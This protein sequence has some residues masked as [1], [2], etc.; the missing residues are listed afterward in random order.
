MFSRMQERATI[1]ENSNMQSENEIVQNIQVAPPENEVQQEQQDYEP[2]VVQPSNSTVTGANAPQTNYMIEYIEDNYQSKQLHEQFLFD[3]Y[4]YQYD[5]EFWYNLL[6]NDMTLITDYRFVELSMIKRVVEINNNPM[7]KWLGITNTRLQNIFNIENDFIVQYYALGIIGTTLVFAPYFIFLG[8]FAFKTIR[9]KFK[10]LNIINL[11]A[12]ITIVFLFGIA[13][14]TGNLLNS[15]SFTI[16]FTLCFYL[17]L[18]N[19]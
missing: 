19:K 2:I 6:Q 4:P 3:Y 1:A 15:L 17:I 11:L 7:D 14:F 8:V 10:N 12:C 18:Q 9:Q 5:P 13:Y 16:Y